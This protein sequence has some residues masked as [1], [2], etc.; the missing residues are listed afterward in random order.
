MQQGGEL[1]DSQTR[2]LKGSPK[3]DLFK[4]KHKDLNNKFYATDADFCLV[5]KTPPGTVAYLDYKGSGEGVTFSEVIQYNAWM[6]QAPVY[7]VLGENPETGPFDI[8]RYLGGDWKPNPPTYKTELTKK[9]DGWEQFEE[10]ESVLRN[11]Y[12]KRGGWNGSLRQT[13]P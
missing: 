9:C 11:E 3:R 4:R 2:N 8:Y 5:S 1:V 12:Q 7:L 6:M 13:T 10:W